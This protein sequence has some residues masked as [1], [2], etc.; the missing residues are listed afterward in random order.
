MLTYQNIASRLSIE[1]RDLDSA[2]NT[3]HYLLSLSWVIWTEFDTY[4]ST[5]TFSEICAKYR[6]FLFPYFVDADA[7]LWSDTEHDGV[8]K[9]ALLEELLDHSFTK[10]KDM[11]PSLYLNYLS[12][13]YDNLLMIS[14]NDSS[15]DQG[16]LIKETHLLLQ[17][18]S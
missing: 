16:A 3:Y 9:K 7:L 18:I 12:E 13:I 10:I 1:K 17:K 6:N 8:K 11:A 5:P 2:R 14:E 15:C 4:W